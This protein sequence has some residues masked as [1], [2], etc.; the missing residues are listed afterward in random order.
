MS[1]VAARNAGVAD[2][3]SSQPRLREP[4]SARLSAEFFSV[5]VETVDRLVFDVWVCAEHLG[6]T[7][8]PALVERIAREHLLGVVNSSPPSL[9]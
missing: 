2:G 3:R 4:V 8:T 7:V 1:A 6:V 9:R 5:P